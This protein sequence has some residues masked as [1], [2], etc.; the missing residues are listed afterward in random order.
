MQN[1]TPQTQR[2]NHLHN[3]KE[4]NVSPIKEANC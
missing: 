2:F 4:D 3:K 1:I